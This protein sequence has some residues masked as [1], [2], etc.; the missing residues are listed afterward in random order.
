MGIGGQYDREETIQGQASGG[1]ATEF[2][3]GPDQRPGVGGVQSGVGIAWQDFGG[4]IS[5][6]DWQATVDRIVGI[7]RS[8]AASI[9]GI[10]A[11]LLSQARVQLGKSEECIEWYQR[12]AEELRDYIAD[13]EALTATEAPD[14]NG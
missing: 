12:E 4:G 6:A 1:G 8:H 2:G 9:G 10:H 7:L 14:G 5:G 3:S 11:Q 13:L